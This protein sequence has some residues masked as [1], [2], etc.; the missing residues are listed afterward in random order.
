VLGGSI[1]DAPQRAVARLQPAIPSPLSGG[2]YLSCPW[3][4]QVCHL[5]VAGPR[6]ASG[7]FTTRARSPLVRFWLTFHFP[8]SGDLNFIRRLKA[9]SDCGLQSRYSSLRCITNTAAEHAKTAKANANSSPLSPTAGKLT[10]SFVR[11]LTIA[12]GLRR[13]PA[14]RR[15]PRFAASAAGRRQSIPP[16]HCQC[17]PHGSMPKV[18]KMYTDSLA[19]VNLKKS[20]WSRIT[21]AIPRSTQ[22]VITNALLC[23]ISDNALRLSVIPGPW[24]VQLKCHFLGG[25]DCRHG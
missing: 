8:S 4:H 20:V 2:G 16:R 9:G 5:E 17:G 25:R 3:L 10:P 6:L 13:A 18:E 14:L 7:P 23:D 24:G 11:W 21:A 15:T 19:P 22:L 1:G 12:P